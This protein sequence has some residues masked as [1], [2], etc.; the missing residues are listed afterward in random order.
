MVSGIEE[1]SLVIVHCSNPREKM[2]GA[3]VRLDGAGVVVR[4]LDLESVEDWLRQ[5]KA[6]GD[7][8]IHPTTFFVPMQRILRLD[9]DES[10]VSVPSYGDRF[11][12]A[13]GR[14]VRDALFSSGG[15]DA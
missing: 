11:L 6:G 12:A 1:G 7:T 10:T 13:C 5:E 14:D 15:P 4:G 8:L 9:L 3:V 2:W